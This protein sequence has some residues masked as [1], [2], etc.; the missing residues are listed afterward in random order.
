M[1]LVAMS[2]ANNILSLKMAQNEFSANKQF[3]QTT[4]Q[5]IDDV[6]WTIGR[7]QTITFSSRFGVVKFQEVALN[8]TFRICYHNSTWE[9]LT[10]SGETGIL[11]FNV[12]I[13]S[14]SMANN[15]FERVPYAANSSFVLA[16]STAPVTQVFCEQKIP[17]TDGSYLRIVLIPTI[18]VLNSTGYFKFYLP[19]LQNGTSPY[20]TRSLTLTGEG[21]SRIVRNNIDQVVVTVS[22]PKAASIGFDADFFKFNNTTMTFNST[23]TP[24]LNPDSVIEFYTGKVLVSIGQV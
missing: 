5:Q 2:F 18:R 4:G 3:M 23:S 17:M 20:Q 11:L 15:Y 24:K 6:A 14:Y 10:V 7:T 21:I 22:F 9:N 8:Y 12:P 16:G 19:S 1:I 13:S